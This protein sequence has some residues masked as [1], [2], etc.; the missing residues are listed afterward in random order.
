M[1]QMS[2]DSQQ[3]IWLKDKLPIE[4]RLRKDAEQTNEILRDKLEKVQEENRILKRRIKMQLEENKEEM[5]LQE[6]FYKDIMSRT[7]D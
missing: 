7:R 1:R 6:E 2:A 4:Q 5:D 3:V